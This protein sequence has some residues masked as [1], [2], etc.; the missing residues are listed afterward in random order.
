MILIA[1]SDNDLVRKSHQDNGKAK[2]SAQIANQDF[3]NGRLYN[4]EIGGERSTLCDWD[5]DR[6]AL[7]LE[8]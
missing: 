2:I 5:I 6:A 3:P 4:L 1:T 7:K 8:L